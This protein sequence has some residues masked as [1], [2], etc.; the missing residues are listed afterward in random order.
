MNMKRTGCQCLL[1]E[2]EKNR[3]KKVIMHPIFNGIL[4]KLKIYICIY[5]SIVFGRTNNH[6]FLNPMK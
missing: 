4:F 2:A 5:L 1:L 6:F 3:K